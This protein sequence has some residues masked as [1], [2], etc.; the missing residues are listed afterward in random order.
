MII[1][2]AFLSPLQAQVV[3]VNPVFPKLNDDVTVTF[4]A[5]QGNGALMGVSP[6]YAHTGVITSESTNPSDWKHV[7]G[8]W[9]TPDPNVL[10][11]GIGNN[12]HTLSYNIKNYYGINDGETVESLAFVFRN[13]SGSIVGRASDGADIFYPVYP[14]DVEFLSVLLS[15]QE[16]SLALF[17]GEVITVK[18]ATSQDADLFIMD[19][20]DV[21]ATGFGV[22]I[23]HNLTV[24]EAGNHT[25]RFIA[26]R[27]TDTLEQS[28]FYTTIVNI[29]TEDPPAGRED[30]LTLPS[31][32]SAYFQLYAPNK[33]V[34]HLVGDMTNWDLLSEYQ[35]KRSEDGTTWWIEVPGLTT[36]QLYRYQY[37]VDG[38]LRIGDPYSTL[39]LDPW[40]DGVITSETYPNMP[41][42]PA[43]LTTGN[44]SVFTMQP[45]VPTVEPLSPKIPKS[46]LIVYELLLRDFLDAHS[47]KSL[48]DTL[49]YLQRLGVNAI[50]LM[51]INEFEGNYGWGYNPSYHMALDKFYGPA[52]EFRALVEEAHSR[53]MVVILDVV[54]NHA[55]GQSPF[56]QLYWDVAQNRPSADNPWLNPVAKHDFNVGYDFNHE[57]AATKYFV[58]RVTRYWL[59]TFG[60]DGFRF[61]LSK[62]FTQNNTLG[63]ISAWGAYDQSRINIWQDYAD[64]VWSIDPE[65]YIILEHFAN[66]DEEAELSSRG[67]MLWGNSNHAYSQA[68]QG[69]GGSDLSNSW[70]VTRGWDEPHLISYMESHDEERVMYRNITNGNSAPNYNIRD[71]FTALGRM[72]LVAPF[73][74]LV[75]GPKMIW[76]FGEL[77]YDYSINYCTNGTVNNNCRLDPKPI[78]WDYLEVRERRRIYDVNRAVIRLRQLDA[79]KQGDFTMSLASQFEKKIHVEHA[80]TDIIAVGNFHVG[81]RNIIPAFTKPGTW[82]DYLDGGTLQ[83][84]NV[85]TSITYKPGEYHIYTSSFVDP[86]F[87]IISGVRDIPISSVPLVLRPSLNEGDFAFDLPV[88]NRDFELAVYSISGS[89]MDA[90]TILQ[91]NT[92]QVRMIDAPPGMY[93]V[94]CI[95]EQTRYIGKMIVR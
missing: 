61:D 78:R 58:K 41:A 84:A 9:G 69:Y 67:M 47:F 21:L 57:S 44:V 50:Q 55:F 88:S 64:H 24:T 39:I 6:V 83:I 82:Y 19:N 91:D 35:M 79:W 8:N 77:G 45:I 81:D 93:W 18:G 59:E 33:S 28:F 87:E 30:G 22:S 89:R 72:G 29:V 2:T 12:K 43:A 11:T 48:R 26:V 95:V 90:K 74:F 14:N 38:S 40:N 65:A 42:Y 71:Q 20:D 16:S 37:V 31:T 63:N 17:E 3:E 46:D 92:V 27:G 62:G 10:M 60:I 25:V 51:P 4:N 76:E 56:A 70:Y 23:Q 13:A 52:D 66:N 7:Q 32:T 34:V 53:G 75:P 94:E 15:P 54:Y 49:D 1:L 85:D 80:D 73:F 36:D 5:T 86:G 68:A